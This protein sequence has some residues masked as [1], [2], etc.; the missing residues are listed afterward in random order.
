MLRS[1]HYAA[2]AGLFNQ[3]AWGGKHAERHA[4][5]TLEPWAVW[6][7]QGVSAVFLD[8]YLA[9]AGQA[10]FLPPTREERQILLEIFLLE[11]AFYELGY[12]LN[13]RP[14][15]VWIPLQGIHQ[16]TGAV[17]GRS[18]QQRNLGD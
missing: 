3:T 16:L 9:T 17:R 6:W 18:G 7:W 4:F 11:K 5:V 2:Y 8:T 12:E 14:D 1:F 10:G 15:W 13:N